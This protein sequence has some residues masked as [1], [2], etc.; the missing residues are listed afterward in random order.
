MLQ[1]NGM[2]THKRDDVGL[3]NLIAVAC[4]SQISVNDHKRRSCV[5]CYSAPYHYTAPA[6]ETTFNNT[7]ILVPFSNSTVYPG[8]TITAIQVKTWLVRIRAQS[9]LVKR[10]LALHYARRATWW[11]RCRTGRIAGRRG[12]MFR[13]RKW[14]LTVLGLMFLKP[15]MLL[16]VNAAVWSRLRRC[17]T[18]MCLDVMTS[19]VDVPICDGPWRYQIADNRLHKTEIVFLCTPNRLLTSFWDAPAR[20]MPTA[21]LRWALLSLGIAYQ[22]IQEE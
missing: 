18:R 4:T 11:R 7:V 21:W 20:I 17:V 12:R 22:H 10:R 5:S 14:F 15:G 13:S 19:H 2:L 9:C 8:T 3:Q 1:R 16:A 6:K